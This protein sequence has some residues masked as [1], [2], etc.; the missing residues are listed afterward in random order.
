MLVLVLGIGAK[1]LQHKKDAT[2]SNANVHAFAI[3]VVE[4]ALEDSSCKK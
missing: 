3:M 4:V 2:K 1:Q